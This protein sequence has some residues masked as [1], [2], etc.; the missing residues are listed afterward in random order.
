MATG[1]AG[2]AAEIRLI[3]CRGKC[4]KKKSVACFNPS[5]L[6]REKPICRECRADYRPTPR[7]SKRVKGVAWRRSNILL[8]T[9]TAKGMKK[10]EGAA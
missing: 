1:R 4:G 9:G 7:L 8:Y 10:L 6:K 2:K 3:E 5:D